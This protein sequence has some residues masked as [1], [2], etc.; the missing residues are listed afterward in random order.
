MISIES[1]EPDLA[2]LL[3]PFALKHDFADHPLMS[4]DAM[5]ELVDEL[6]EGSIELTRANSGAVA[7]VDYQPPVFEGLARDA[8]KEVE[9][10]S[11]SVFIYNVERIDRYRDLLAEALDPSSTRSRSTP[12]TSSPVR[13][14]SSAPVGAVARPPAPT[15]TSS[16]T[17]CSSP[18]GGS[19]STS[20]MCPMSR[21]SWRSKRCTRAFTAH[22]AR[23]RHP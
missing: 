19:G 10:Q 3:R 17:S 22:V 5:A 4:V 18:R 8:L 16:A 7:S 11:R 1:S 23:F 14:T 20:P 12:E 13:A 6:P 21:V 9:G 2:D 15:S